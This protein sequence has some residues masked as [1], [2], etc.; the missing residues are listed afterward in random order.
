MAN[1][2]HYTKSAR[3]RD[4]GRAPEIMEGVVAAEYRD[5]RNCQLQGGLQ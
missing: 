2:Y 1:Q 3:K 4:A 5:R